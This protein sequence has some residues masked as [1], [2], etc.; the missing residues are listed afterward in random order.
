MLI[1]ECGCGGEIVPT[2][3]HKYDGTPRFL[4][5][6]H[7]KVDAANGRAHHRY[8]PDPSE[9]PGGQCECGCGAATTTAELTVRAKRE[10]RGHPKP[11][12]PFHRKTKVREAHGNWKGGRIKSRGYV[13]VFMPEHPHAD[14]KGYVREH[15]L[16]VEKRLGRYLRPDEHV[17]HVNH[18]KDDNR[19]ENLQVMTKGEHTTEHRTGAKHTP[20]V[21]EK[22]RESG[23]RG[24]AAR[25]GRRGV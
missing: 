13:L 16:V 22:L 19:D 3:K 5:G 6:H 24:A 11:Y 23:R 10:F 9:I 18:V 2:R 7:V 25:W 20:E 15:R 14:P 8:I 12:L 17:H 1:C 21:V 4:Q